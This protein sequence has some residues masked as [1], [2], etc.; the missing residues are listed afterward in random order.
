VVLA[1]SLNG[2]FL[3]LGS[4]ALV[5]VSPSTPLTLTWYLVVGVAATVA[6]FPYRSALVERVRASSRV[7][8]TALIAGVVLAGWFELNAIFVGRSALAIHF[9]GLLLLWSLPAAVLAFSMP[10]SAFERVA[11]WVAALGLL[12][13][14]IEG[15]ALLRLSGS[16]QR[17][18]PIAYLDPISAGGIC[19]LG[20]V[21]LVSLRTAGRPRVLAQTT[22]AAA[23]VAGSAVSGSRGPLL[24]AVTGCIAVA[25]IGRRRT[26]LIAVVAIAVGVVVGLQLARSTGTYAYLTDSVPGVA[27]S[28]G[29][30]EANKPPPPS[31]PAIS[32]VHIRL[33]WLQ[34]AL[35]Q[36][37]RRPVF[38]HGIAQ[39]VDATPEAHRMGVAG[40]R[41]YPHNSLAEA[42]FS[43]GLLGLIPYLALIGAAAIALAH[44]ARTR[45]TAAQ[46]AAGFAGVAAIS[47]SVSGEIGAD[48][49][50][51]AAAGLA[52]GAYAQ[53][54]ARSRL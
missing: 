37:P 13:L 42:A 54:A 24:A 1:I 12:F 26:R 8:R 20:A 36:A 10:R 21:S 28:P 34:T 19:A 11:W 50:A 47:T 43:L 22:L 52:L 15:I 49:V 40:Q 7:V 51:W 41:I 38:G 45:S 18:S 31:V 3:Y 9:A 30:E 2:F 32:T 4:L 48:A 39:F 35:K 17:F 44:L 16:V 46:V 53:A 5:N 6:A 23:L 33:E 25:L 29:G 14:S 27:S